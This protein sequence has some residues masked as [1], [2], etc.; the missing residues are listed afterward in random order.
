MF[1]HVIDPKKS[2]FFFLAL[3]SWLEIF[4]INIDVAFFLKKN[5]CCQCRRQAPIVPM[6]A[7]GHLWPPDQQQCR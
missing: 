3:C 5:P 4:A 6:A 7:Y 1:S 2:Q